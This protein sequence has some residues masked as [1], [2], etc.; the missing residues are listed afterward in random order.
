MTIIKLRRDSAANW[1]IADSVLNEGEI[2]VERDTGRFKIGD[3][4][5]R[6]TSL[7]YFYPGVGNQGAQGPPGPQGFPGPQGPQGPEGPQGDQGSQGVQGPQ[8]PAGADSTVPGPQGPIG[9]IGPTGAEGAPGIQ[10]PQGPTGPEGD[11]GPQGL[12]GSQGPAGADSTVPGPEGPEGPEGPPGDVGAQGIQG[13]PGPAGAD[14]ATGPAG[15]AGPLE[16]PVPSWNKLKAWTYDPIHADTSSAS[17]AGQLLLSKIFI[18]EDMTISQ[19]LAWVGTAYT[20]SPTLLGAGLYDGSGHQTGAGVGQRH[21]TT[22]SQIGAWNTTG[23]KVMNLT[24]D[25]GKSLNLI[26]GDD[27]WMYVASLQVGGTA[28]YGL[29]RYNQAGRNNI[30]LVAADG[31]RFAAL[32]AQTSLPTSLTIGSLIESPFPCWAGLR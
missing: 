23:Q 2:G 26:G 30:G 24:A 11:Q 17:T 21:S 4:V 8:G 10:G 16:S 5:S 31:W 18:L 12:Q 14:G 9:P 7:E 32:N 19:L 27:V 13:I 15:P 3:G 22:P 28:A 20:G 25:A 6:W 1:F 29:A